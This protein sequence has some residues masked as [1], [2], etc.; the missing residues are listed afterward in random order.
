[1]F[2]KTGAIACPAG[3]EAWELM[4][5]LHDSSVEQPCLHRAYLTARAL[6]LSFEQAQSLCKVW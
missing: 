3:I 6:R 2:C 4:C 1:M 5:Q